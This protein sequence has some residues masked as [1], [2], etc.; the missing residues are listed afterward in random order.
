[1][2]GEATPG[3]K[4]ASTRD[5]AARAGVNVPVLQYYFENKKGVYQTY[6]EHIAND[7]WMNFE[8]VITVLSQ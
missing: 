1:V 5:I 4:A 3:F 2:S 8:P 7:A 6:P